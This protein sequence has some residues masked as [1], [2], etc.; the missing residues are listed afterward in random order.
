[1]PQTFDPLQIAL[2]QRTPL[3]CEQA[4]RGQAAK[5]RKRGWLVLKACLARADFKLIHEVVVEPWINELRS[6]PEVP[7]LLTHLIARRGGSVER[8]TRLLEKNGISLLSLRSAVENPEVSRNRLVVLRGIAGKLEARKDGAIVP[9]TETV[10]R[11]QDSYHAQWAAR[12]GYRGLASR[13]L[14]NE[15]ALTGREVIARVARPLP[16]LSAGKELIFLVRFEGMRA[17]DTAGLEA[18]WAMVSI[19]AVFEPDDLQVY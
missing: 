3:D 18:P 10:L 12:Q 8:D 19:Q 15:V 13:G 11:S 9:L 2:R 1:M 4:A 5:S 6:D 14:V 16:K 7:E 17:S